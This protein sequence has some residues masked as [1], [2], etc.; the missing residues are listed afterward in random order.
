MCAAAVD[1]GTVPGLVALVATGGQTVFHEAFGARQ[2]IPRKLPTFPDT[3]YDVASLT[4]AV[5]TSV[6]AM[7]EVGAGRLALDATVAS[8]LPEFAGPGRD[9]VTVRQLLCH[10][11][12]LP[13]HRPFWRQAA[14]A[15]AERWTISRL[16]AREPL[17]YPPGSRSVYSDLGFILLGWLLERTTGVRLDVLTQ[18]HIA[19]PLGLAATTFVSLADPEAPA[20]LLGDRSVAATQL[21]PE[22]RRLMLGEVDDLNAAAMG[23]IA[24]HAGLFS[25]AADLARIAGALTAVW[26]GE[27]TAAGIPGVERDVVRTFWSPSGIPGS[28]W[29]LGWDGPAAT[30]SQAGAR[31]SREAVGHLGFTGCSL[32]IDPAREIWIVLLSNR[33]HQSPPTDDRFRH[34]RPALHDAVAEALGYDC[35]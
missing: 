29:R 6:L 30:G 24:G 18:D 7:G 12:G 19:G 9:E 31:L 13:A 16:A 21:C 8:L 27:G 34:F 11:S 3:V 5:V 15:P 28:N 32:W 25:S 4:K 1:E 14:H 22:R 23:G 26:R 20:R 35:S 33:L 2:L 10:A 17:E